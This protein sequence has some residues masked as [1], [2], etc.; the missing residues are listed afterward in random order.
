VPHVP[1]SA[2]KTV[3]IAEAVLGALKA[4]GANTVL[5]LR[6][7]GAAPVDG[8]ASNDAESAVGCVETASDLAAVCLR[9][10]LKVAFAG[11]PEGH[12]S[13]LDGVQL[14]RTK[15]AALHCEAAAVGETDVVTQFSFNAAAVS[16][17]LDAA[18]SCGAA[19]VF[20]GVAGPASPN[21]LRKF[22]ALCHVGP[23]KLLAD[24]EYA[25][26][27][28]AAAPCGARAAAPG[29]LMRPTAAVLSLAAYVLRRAAAS[30]ECADIRLH[31]YPF[32]GIEAA[33]L[34]LDDLES[35]AWPTDAALAE[36]Y[37]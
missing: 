13:K 16:S 14:L 35:G 25:D 36:D 7:N 33:L 30:P 1:A 22:A 24:A 17:F 26:A 21:V 6:G 19:S 20:V 18:A 5:C 37:L 12:P 27:T 9:L 3:R 29:G 31:V 11:F 28:H 15:I 8:R 34:L 32:G 2:L 4:A 10:G 23:S